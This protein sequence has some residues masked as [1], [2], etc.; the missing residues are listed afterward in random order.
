[1]DTA[2]GGL[3]DG[4]MVERVGVDDERLGLRGGNQA[5]E[6]GEQPGG[7]DAVRGAEL[8]AQPGVGVVDTDQF[9]VG[10][11][12]HR[13]HVPA[14]VPV[15]E[16]GDG[17]TQRPGLGG[18]LCPRGGGAGE[19]AGG[20]EDET[21]QPREAGT[22]LGLGPQGGKRSH[23]ELRGCGTGR[24]VSRGREAAATP[25]RWADWTFCCL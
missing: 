17:D 16:A 10:P 5:I 20:D 3:D 11:L 18:G 2:S 13:V 21:S 6:I 19:Q 8:L 15:H 7:V 24:S 4:E 14:D 1:V 12:D 22:R 9:D 23:R 25:P